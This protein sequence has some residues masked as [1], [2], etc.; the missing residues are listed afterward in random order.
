M[1]SVRRR[2]ILRLVVEG[3]LSYVP[4]FRDFDVCLICMGGSGVG[5]AS[6]E[7]CCRELLEEDG[8]CG[9]VVGVWESI[10]MRVSR[11]SLSL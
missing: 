8:I 11:G 10:R 3:G 7:E 2:L 5:G 6:G 4:C 1:G 9:G